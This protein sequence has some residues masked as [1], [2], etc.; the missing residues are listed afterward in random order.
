VDQSIDARERDPRA[1][2]RAWRTVRVAA[3]L[4]G[5][6]LAGVL[7]VEPPAALTS[8]LGEAAAAQPHVPAADRWIAL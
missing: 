8:M 1:G 5:L 6:G 2:R 3:L 7:T 4:A